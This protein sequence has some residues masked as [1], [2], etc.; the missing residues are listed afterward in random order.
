MSLIELFTTVTTANDGYTLRN[1]TYKLIHLNTGKEYLYKISIDP[2]EQTNL[3]LSSL[4]TEAQQNLDALR[5]IK[6]GL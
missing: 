5:L 6:V 3:L 4:S 2:T 1:N